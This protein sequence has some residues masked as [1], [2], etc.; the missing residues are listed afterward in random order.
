MVITTKIIDGCKRNEKIAQKQLYSL[1]LPYLNPVCRRYLN[2]PSDIKD[3]LQETFIRVFS[4]INQYDPERAQFKTWVV[5]ITINCA[6][7]YN[8][9]MYQLPTDELTEDENTQII[10]P[11]IL[12]KLS[13]D[14]LLAF[15]KTMPKQYFDVFN[16]YTIDGFSHKEIGSI[17]GIDE[18]LSRKR[19][20]RARIW[21]ASK[22]GDR[23]IEH[24]R[25]RKFI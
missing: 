13:D 18:R 17:L 10:E 19:L 6:L 15:F 8:K 14:D 25:L 21:L 5:K 20:S 1:L 3:T 9:K 4:N 24:F 23:N 7:K 16:L 12:I 22:I 2:N 11:E